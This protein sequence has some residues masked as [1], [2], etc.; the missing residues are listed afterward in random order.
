MVYN[1]W[2]GYVLPKGTPD[3]IADYWHDQIAE[4]FKAPAVERVYMQQ[5]GNLQA[6]AP[7]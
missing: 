7:R 3:E 1:I 4:A 6:R 2:Q 5:K